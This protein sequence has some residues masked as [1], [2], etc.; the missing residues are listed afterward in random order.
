MCEVQAESHGLRPRPFGSLCYFIQVFIIRV[1][2]SDLN[3][4]A[5]LSHENGLS[6]F[7]SRFV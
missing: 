6:G 1:V 7:L 5:F 4:V 3:T 2:E